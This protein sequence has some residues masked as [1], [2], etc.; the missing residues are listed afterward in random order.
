[1]HVFERQDLL[2]SEPSVPSCGISVWCSLVTALQAL[3]GTDLPC[4]IGWTLLLLLRGQVHAAFHESNT[5]RHDRPALRA[6]AVCFSS[7]NVAQHLII[8]DS[9]PGCVSLKT[10]GAGSHGLSCAFVRVY[11]FTHRHSACSL[12]PSWL[13]YDTDFRLLTNQPSSRA[14]AITST[15]RSMRASV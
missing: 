6:I 15:M 7:S 14:A 8:S 11:Q 1:M 9:L 12:H 10:Q 5:N 3:F 2:E 4:C 13:T